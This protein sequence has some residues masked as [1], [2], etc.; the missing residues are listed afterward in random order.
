M[1][2]GGI[3]Y[4]R[5]ETLQFYWRDPTPDPTRVKSPIEAKVEPRDWSHHYDPI[6]SLIR[7]N[8]DYLQRMLTTPTLMP[9][10]EADIHIGI[11]P[12]VLRLVT[13][14]NW[15]EAR[16]AVQLDFTTSGDIQYQRDGIAVVAGSSW[17]QPLKETNA[18]SGG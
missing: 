18:I 9:V 5:R 13:A 10:P 16:H 4:L 6:L 7:S 8:Q 11:H 1:N 3:A 2:I 12:E 15:E 14:G 17:L